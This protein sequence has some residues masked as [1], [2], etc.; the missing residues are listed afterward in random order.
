MYSTSFKVVELEL[1][2]E[3]ELTE[4]ELT[5]LELTEELDETDELDELTELLLTELEDNE[6]LLLEIP[7]EL[8]LVDEE[9]SIKIEGFSEITTKN[10]VDNLDW[11]VKFIKALS[12]FATFKEKVVVGNN[13]EGLKVVF[14]G[15]RDAELSD[16]VVARGGKVLTSISKNVNILV[17]AVKSAKLTGKTKKA[18]ELGITIM[19]K[20]EFINKYIDNK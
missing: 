12:N 17:V 15:F 16:K 11:A 18:E 1:N 4:L 9:D 19:G 14:S 3:L 5:E 13:M 2:E 7:V 10:I 8:E 20:D 6:E